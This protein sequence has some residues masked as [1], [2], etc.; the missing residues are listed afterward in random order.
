MDILREGLFLGAVAYLYQ[1]VTK[2]KVMENVNLR[3][4]TLGGVLGL[5]IGPKIEQYIKSDPDIS[6]EMKDKLLG[7]G[8][9]AIGGY[10]FGDKIKEQAKK[11][12]GGLEKKVD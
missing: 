4:A 3:Y 1:E 9:G 2:Q 5:V 11:T 6:S 10:A 8:I 12:F 7:A